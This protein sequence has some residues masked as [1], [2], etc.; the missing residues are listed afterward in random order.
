MRS[1]F[2]LAS[3]P[4]RTLGWGVCAWLACAGGAHAAPPTPLENIAHTVILGDTLERLAQQYLGDARRWPVL[5]ASNHVGNPRRLQPG[6]VLHIPVRLLPSAPAKVEFVHGSVVLASA[7]GTAP[8][9]TGQQI[10]EG[11]RLQAGPDAFVSV[12]L[13]D[14]SVVR[15]QAQT[16]VQL[17]Q[18]RRRGRAGSLQSVLEMHSG[19]L[20]TSV[21]NQHEE[22][23][24]FEIR[25]PTASTSVRGTRFDVALAPDGRTT[26]A[27]VEGSVAVQAAASK[28]PA[29]PSGTLLQPGQGLAVSATGELGKPRALLPAPDLAA[30]PEAL[31][32]AALLTLPLPSPS[33]GAAA[34]QVRIARDAQLTQVLR[35]GT[36]S[37]PQAT[38]QGLEDGT[39][40]VAVR[41]LD[42]AGI[43]GY[44][45]QRTLLVKT[46]PIPPLAQSPAPS[47]TLAR[48]QGELRCTEVPGV[49][50][51]HLQVAREP[52]FRDVVLDADRQAD[53]RLALADLPTGSYHWRAASVQQ[54]TNG[55]AD[56][57]PFSPPQPF[58]VADRPTALQSLQAQDGGPS[59]ALHWAAQ[60]GQSFR[61]QVARDTTFAQPLEDTRLS[62]PTW[63]AQGLPAGAYYVR[64]QVLS[65]AGLQSDFSQPRKITVGGSVQD[66]SGQP[67]R[68]PTG[69]AVQSQ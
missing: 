54:P 65:D 30:L 23:R 42:D 44:P 34:W 1:T 51:Y 43:P 15:V 38:W 40:Y 37:G 48:G 41:G 21:P 55:P 9:Q 4:L 31:H 52:A 8:V 32:D 58:T 45:A 6:S 19:S 2:L 28:T 62:Q 50:W 3:P 13:A 18:M 7:S 12:Q 14:G 68:S 39:Y 49:R 69:A 59:V 47:A 53:C 64:I 35:Q 20:E 25:T 10:D 16:D 29:T 46:R 17:R 26:T 66:S 24:R 60:P 36:F 33:G 67:L 63:V 5:Q 56:Q 27:V 61:L 11:A 22:L 57:G